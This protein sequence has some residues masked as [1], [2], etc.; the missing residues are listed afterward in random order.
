MQSQKKRKYNTQHEHCTV[1]ASNGS[2]SAAH[3]AKYC[4]YKGGPFYNEADPAAG[5]K[6]AM[7][8]KRSDQKTVSLTALHS[9]G[10]GIRIKVL[11]QELK[12]AFGRIEQL[13]RLTKT[14]SEQISKMSTWITK[15]VQQY[16]GKGKGKGV[17][18]GKGKGE[19]HSSYSYGDF[20]Y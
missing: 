17:S 3:T 19:Y 15:T 20:D 10:D 13:E 1:C 11:E 4:A 14:Q 18:K 5:R 9:R 8:Q 7:L 6:A 12:A 2:N 16:K